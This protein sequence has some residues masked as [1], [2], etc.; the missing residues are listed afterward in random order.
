MSLS[1]TE[2]SGGGGKSSLEKELWKEAGVKERES[3]GWV[4]RERAHLKIN[5][6]NRMR[7]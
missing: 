7:D 1:I 3:G 5:G 6:M 4:E 2:G